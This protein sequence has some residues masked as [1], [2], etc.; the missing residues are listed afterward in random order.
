MSHRDLGISLGL[1]T[2]IRPDQF[3]ACW[4]GAP[5]RCR[6]LTP[7]STGIAVPVMKDAAGK[8][9]KAMASASCSGSAHRCIGTNR[10]SA[11]KRRRSERSMWS[12][13]PVRIGPGTTAFARTSLVGRSMAIERTR[14]TAPAFA[15]ACGQRFGSP[16]SAVTDAITTTARPRFVS[17][18]AR[19]RAVPRR[20]RADLPRSS[21]RIRPCCRSPGLL[22]RAHRR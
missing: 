9:R 19:R 3:L 21:G 1:I 22:F 13:M 6:A 2:A 16:P 15:A 12:V 10:R 8:A 5:V 18:R 20:R 11:S 7:P 4:V 14:F 17:L